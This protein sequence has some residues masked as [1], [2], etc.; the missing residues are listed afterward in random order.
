[1]ESVFYFGSPQFIGILFQQGLFP[2]MPSISAHPVTKLIHCTCLQ[3]E[4]I[5]RPNKII[6][7]HLYLCWHFC[8]NILI[9]NHTLKI[10]CL[11]LGLNLDPLLSW[12]VTPSLLKSNQASIFLGLNLILDVFFVTFVSLLVRKK[13]TEITTFQT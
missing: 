6:R 13:A 3:S 10:L 9:C 5:Y 11:F 7:I 1:M 4:D 12:G 2:T 8:S